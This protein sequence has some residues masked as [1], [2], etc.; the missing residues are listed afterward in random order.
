MD[1]ILHSLGTLT[2]LYGGAKLLQGLAALHAFF[3]RKGKRLSKYGEWAV[4][5]GATDGIG[6][7]YAM[8]LAR[9]GLSVLLISRTAEKLQEVEKELK[10]KYPKVQASHLAIDYSNFDAKAW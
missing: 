5:T 1:T 6:R 4:V 9:N 10:E 3:L 7:A 8:E 2:L